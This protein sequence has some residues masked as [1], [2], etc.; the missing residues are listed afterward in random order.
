MSRVKDFVS[1]REIDIQALLRMVKYAEETP[2]KEFDM[3]NWLIIDNNHCKTS[4]CLCGTFIAKEQFEKCIIEDH[5]YGAVNIPEIINMREL[6][7]KLKS[8]FQLTDNEFSF[9][10]TDHRRNLV[11]AIINR[12]RECL[13]D[14]CLCDD[15][16]RKYHPHKYHSTLRAIQSNIIL[17]ATYLTK[18]QAIARLRKFIY[19]KLRKSE[20]LADYEK[21]RRIESNQQFVKEASLNQQNVEKFAKCF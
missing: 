19:Y 16:L 11:G 10:F 21:S 18:Q 5:D 14:D 6:V 15:C 8:D 13:C 9:L 1:G 7:S 2:E 3:C 4:G 17:N 20:L 12:A